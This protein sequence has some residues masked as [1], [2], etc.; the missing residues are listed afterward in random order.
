M[1]GETSEQAFESAADALAAIG[2]LRE[3]ALEVR[4][5]PV[6]LLILLYDLYGERGGPVPDYGLKLSPY[7]GDTALRALVEGGY[8]E[9]VDD[10]SYAIHAYVPTDL[11]RELVARLSPAVERPARKRRR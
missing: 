10:A 7:L 5:Y 8:V 1:S 2:P 9:R 3:L 6:R 4:T 11:A